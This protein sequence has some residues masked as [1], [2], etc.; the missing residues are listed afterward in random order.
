MSGG[1][2]PNLQRGSKCKGPGAG[3]VFAGLRNSKK[4]SVFRDSRVP[5]RDSR[6]HLKR[7]WFT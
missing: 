6:S 4:V 7:I 1:R 2:Y 5:S 3:M